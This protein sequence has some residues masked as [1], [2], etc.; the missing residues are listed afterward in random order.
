MWCPA[1]P[2]VGELHVR[3]ELLV[4]VLV[5]QLLGLEAAHLCPHHAGQADWCH[6]LNIDS[7]TSLHEIVIE[8]DEELS[9]VY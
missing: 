4:G 3:A 2:S 6:G 1:P 5:L 7:V 8:N 9:Y